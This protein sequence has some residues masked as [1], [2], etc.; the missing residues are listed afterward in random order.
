MPPEQVRE[1][2]RRRLLR[3]MLEHV[4]SQGYEATT[5]P[6]VVATARVS[7]NA[8][9]ELF[10]D[11]ADC[12]LAACD[13]L[14]GDLL[15]RLAAAGSGADWLTTLRQGVKTYLSWW[16][17]RPGFAYAYL[18]CL[19]SAGERAVEQ[20]ERAYEMFR[21]MF[22]ALARRARVEQPSLPPLPGVVP[23]FLVFAITELVA[24]E[25]RAGRT[26]RLPALEDDVAFLAI[27]LLADDTTARRA[28]PG[29]LPGPNSG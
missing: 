10:S 13:E 2:Q 22:R 11:K 29:Y 28:L 18:A 7:R 3:A 25:V 4:A 24:E 19:P 23:R 17:S 1:S 16:A 8:F 5:V 26:A 15:E 9:Y 14:A 27:R 12:F 20:R 21:E 6:A